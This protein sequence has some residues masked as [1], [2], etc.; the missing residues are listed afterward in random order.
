MLVKSLLNSLRALSVMCAVSWMDTAFLTFAV[1]SPSSQCKQIALLGC[2]SPFPSSQGIGMLLLY[3]LAVLRP[4]LARRKKISSAKRYGLLRHVYARLPWF[5]TV[6]FCYVLRAV[7]CLAVGMFVVISSLE[8]VKL[9]S[10]SPLPS[11]G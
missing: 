8:F 10:P 2:F 4:A 7:L 11:T 3:L 5:L 1:S 9:V 6:L